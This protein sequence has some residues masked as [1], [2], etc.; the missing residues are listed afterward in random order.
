MN[1]ATVASIVVI[2]AS[3]VA[4]VI[5]RTSNDSS[6]QSIVKKTPCL[7]SPLLPLKRTW[8]FC[9]STHLQRNPP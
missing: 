8:D 2:V 6:N 4:M 5:K 9:S 7:P 3:I 1:G